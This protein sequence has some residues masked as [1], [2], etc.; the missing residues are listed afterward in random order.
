MRFYIS[1]LI[2]SIIVFAGFYLA[3]PHLSAKVSYPSFAW[4]QLVMIAATVIFQNGLARA[5]Q[6][7]GQVFVRYFMG[8]TS[9]KLMVFMMIIV[10]YALMNREQAFGFIL[11]F[12]VLYLLYTV[13]E[14][15]FAYKSFGPKS[16][17]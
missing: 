13:F 11:H 3:E 4:I 7:N 8:A 14:V 2:F 5:S 12:F 15:Y 6:K 1:L 16:K 9:V 17:T 10:I